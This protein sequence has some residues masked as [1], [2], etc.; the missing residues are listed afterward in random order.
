MT[1]VDV[2]RKWKHSDV[3]ETLTRSRIKRF[4]FGMGR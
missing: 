3:L 2:A 1:P 4:V